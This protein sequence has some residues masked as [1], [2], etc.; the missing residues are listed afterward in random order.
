MAGLGAGVGVAVDSAV[1]DVFVIGAT[2]GLT[3][4]YLKIPKA[5]TNII[6]KMIKAFFIAV[7]YQKHLK[8]LLKGGTQW[9]GKNILGGRAFSFS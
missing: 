1:F 5:V 2:I 6:N 7:L 4:K 3:P 8:I 9:K